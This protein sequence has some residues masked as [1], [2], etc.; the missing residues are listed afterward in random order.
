MIRVVLAADADYI[1]YSYAVCE[2]IGSVYGI[3]IPKKDH[4]D[5]VE[6]NCPSCGKK[7]GMVVRG[8]IGHGKAAM[9]RR[10]DE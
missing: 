7:L 3:E 6:F 9:E 10:T 8:K 5:F 2:C 1:N 4:T